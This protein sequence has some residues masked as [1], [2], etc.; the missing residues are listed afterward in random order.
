MNRD[1]PVKR[2]LLSR[3][4]KLLGASVELYRTVQGGYTPALRLVCKTSEASFF[5]KAGVTPL[6]AEFLHRE[7][8]VYNCVHGEFVPKLIAYD[9]REVEP[10]LIIEDLSA[11]DWQPSW[12]VRKTEVVLAQI[13]AMHN[14]TAQIE[15]YAEVLPARGANWQA[16]AADPAPFLSLGLADST[17]LEAALP[18][19][20]AA[21]VQCKTE[22]KSLCHWD[23][24]SDNICV[25]G[26]KAI[27]VDWN[28][29]CLSN[30]K[31]DLGFWLPSLEFEGG[32]KP[33]AILPNAPE[34]AAFVAG[35]FA[36]RAGLPD[37]PDAPRVR[38]VQRQQLQTALPWAVRALDLPALK[39]I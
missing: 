24:R 18:I 19:L 6:T 39:Q 15:T 10:I 28:I 29:A 31:L 9:E 30:P 35:F 22:G 37:I 7:I 11:Y 21:E 8:H 16:V 25:D 38:L 27:I 12:N 36:A 32:P 4:E 23:L 26:D 1:D 2:E 3:V 33:E 5:V 14:A 17:W 13:E 34:V 20:I